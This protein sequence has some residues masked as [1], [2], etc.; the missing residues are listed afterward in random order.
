MKLGLAAFVLFLLLYSINVAQ[1]APGKELFG[2]P[3]PLEIRLGYAFREL[4][5]SNSDKRY[6]PTYLHYRIDKEAW[7]SIQVDVRARGVYRRKNCFFTPLRV[8]I[9]AKERSGTL[10]EDHKTLKLVLPCQTHGNAND[11]IIKEYLCYKLYELITPYYFRTRLI[12]LRLTD[13]RGRQSKSYDLKAFF[14]EDEDLMAKRLGGKIMKPEE[15]YPFLLQDTSAVRHDF[16]QFMIANTDW[17]AVSQHNIRILQVPPITKIHVPY[18]FDMSGLVNAPYAQV[19]EFLPISNVRERLYRG[20]CR[21]EELFQFIRAEFISFEDQFWGILSE[22]E[23]EIHP[24]EKDRLRKFFDAFFVILKSDR[25]FNE[26]IA[27]KCRT[28]R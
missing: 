4:R 25:E 14:I 11:L 17:S 21:G 7:D 20:F 23:T 27:L 22:I 5:R 19:S 26:N 13:E 15:I 18:D 12:A 3:N 10:F 9:N 8:R 28:T 16:F 6:F 2:N 24:D 1:E